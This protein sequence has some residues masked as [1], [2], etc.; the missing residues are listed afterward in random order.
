MPTKH[1]N[2]LLFITILLIAA[3]LRAPITSVGVA[4]PSIKSTL[5]LSTNEVSLITILPLLAFSVI[6]FYVAKV[7]TRF[8]IEKTLFT[9]LL[10]LLTGILLRAISDVS[11]LYIGTLFIGIGIAFGNVLAPSMIKT[12]FPSRIGIVTG[13]Y[14][15]VM[16]VFGGLSS[17]T[18]ALLTTHYS[19]MVA[20]SLIGVITILTIIIFSFQL[21]NNLIVSSSVKEKAI[22]VWKSPLAW[23]ITLLMG[24]QSLIF[25]TLINWLP[26]ML[27]EKGISTN[28]SGFYLLLLQ[29]AILPFTFIVPIIAAKRASQV[30]IMIMTGIL[31]VLGTLG[32]ICLPAKYIVISIIILGIASGFAFGLVNTL[33]SLR[34][35][36]AQTATKLAGMA[37]SLG[38][39]LAAVGPLLF[40]VVHDVTHN[41]SASLFILLIMAFVILFFASGAGRNQTVE[42]TLQK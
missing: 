38:Y 28:K 34:T 8:G 10:I 25:Y 41:W 30:S 4:L 33:F 40:G 35:E 23:Q 37:Q 36:S 39:L 16:N 15:V 32:L 13:Y 21:R 42:E 12:Y 2:W 20:L 3:N 5:H 14:T 9:S 1:F 29:L 19:Y 22:N 18:T 27:L 17:Y 11:W 7:S 31:F 6:S 24:G 26:E